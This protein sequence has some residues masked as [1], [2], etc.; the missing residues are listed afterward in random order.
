MVWVRDREV[1]VVKMEIG[2]L[3]PEKG[4]QGT[5]REVNALGKF[6]RGRCGFRS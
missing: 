3:D 1:G 2:P 4:V 5:C 6:L